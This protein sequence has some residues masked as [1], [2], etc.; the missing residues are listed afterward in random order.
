LTVYVFPTTVLERDLRSYS[1]RSG[2][3]PDEWLAQ[4][5]NLKLEWKK[6]MRHIADNASY[7]T[8]ALGEFST[9]HRRL[10]TGVV[11][12]MLWGASVLALQAAGPGAQ[13]MLAGEGL[14]ITS[15]E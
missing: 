5:A 6:S 10:L 15:G 14:L 3:K 2:T 9:W 11:V 4:T 13:A 8:P 1:P 12:V 7:Y